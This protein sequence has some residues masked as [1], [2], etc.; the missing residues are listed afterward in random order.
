MTFLT[1]SQETLHFPEGRKG[2]WVRLENDRSDRFSSPIGEQDHCV[3]FKTAAALL[4]A[5]ADRFARRHSRRWLVAGISR[6]R[7]HLSQ[8]LASRYWLVQTHRSFGWRAA[9]IRPG[10]VAA[11]QRLSPRPR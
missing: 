5:L 1:A 8:R 4:Q 2:V 3:G 6:L 9:L 11:D 10:V 7:R